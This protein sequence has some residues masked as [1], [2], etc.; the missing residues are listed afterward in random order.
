MTDTIDDTTEEA[1]G[2]VAD[3]HAHDDHHGPTDAV[4]VKTFV[5]LAIVT[6]LEVAAS[7]VELGVA[8]LPILLGLM[9]AKFFTVVLVF[10]H[11]KYDAAI[12][13]RLF[14]IGLALAAAVYLATLLTFQFFDS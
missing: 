10:M 4:F 12:F 1:T 8:F 3:E 13:G 9:I 5:F 14:Y 2:D 11:V 6:A 7:Y